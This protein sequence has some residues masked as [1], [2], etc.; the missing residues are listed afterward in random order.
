MLHSAA[1][2]LLLL[3]LP[4]LA[5]APSPQEKAPPLVEEKESDHEYP[6][7]IDST[8]PEGAEEKAKEAGEK[9]EPRTLD[10][11]GLAIREKTVFNV[12]VYSYV[13]YVDR[14][15]IGEE[16]AR[17]KGKKR[18]QL[19]KEQGL[20][21]RLLARNCTKEL[22][23]RF[24]RNVDA[25]D[26]VSAF[27]DSLEPRILELKKRAEGSEEDKLATLKRFRGFFSLD[28]LKDGNELR[29]TWHPDGSLSTV[30][31]GERKPDIAD[32]DLAKALF[33]V[34]LGKDPI[35][36]SGR[37]NLIRRLPELLSALK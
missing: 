21:D 13:L 20:F 7:W 14:G 4:P 2:V 30:V 8:L 33:D 18:S 26:V 16:L 9:A 27:E 35:S 34:Y 23:L 12:N 36:N 3:A 32:P 11:L 6:A 37:K 10:L 1:S 15:F 29:F 19:E 28:K 31:N 5:L 17:Y 25:E 22:R 24:C